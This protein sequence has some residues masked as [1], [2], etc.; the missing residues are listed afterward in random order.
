MNL[1]PERSAGRS[2]SDQ[3]PREFRGT[4]TTL[5]DHV[6]APNDDPARQIGGLMLG[7]VPSVDGNGERRPERPDIPTH[8]SRH[9]SLDRRDRTGRS[10]AESN[11]DSSAGGSPNPQEDTQ[12]RRLTQSRITEHFEA[13]GRVR[14]GLSR[15][16]QGRR[17]NVKYRTRAHIRV[18]SLNIRGGGSTATEEK[19]QQ[20]NRVM[21]EGKISVL[22]V[23]ETHLSEERT[24]ELNTQFAGR[25]KIY[26]SNED[27]VTNARGV[28]IVVDHNLTKG[29]PI[30]TRKIIPGRA[31]M[32]TIP[33]KNGREKLTFLAVYA[34]NERDQNALFWSRLSG[35]FDQE[36]EI[37][38]RPDFM[39]G[40]FNLTEDDID[41]LPPRPDN[42]DA[43]E[44]IQVLKQ[45]LEM[46][47]GWRME[48]PE[49]IMY[50]WARPTNQPQNE[51]EVSSKSRIDRIYI[52]RSRFPTSC[53]WKYSSH[54]IRSD[55]DIISAVYYDRESPYIGKGRWAIPE[56]LLKD[57]PFMTEVSQRGY[58]ALVKAQEATATA[59]TTDA[60]PQTV[61]KE[62]KEQIRS[63]AK[64]RS[65]REMP[66]TDARL[67]ELGKT[68]DEI[69][70]D[71]GIPDGE[72]LLRTTNI[73]AESKELEQ[74]RMHTNKAKSTTRFLLENETVGKYWIGL[75]KDKKPRDTIYGLY[76]PG[77]REGPMIH[78]SDQMAKMAKEYHEGL[79]KDGKCLEVGEDVRETAIQS[80]LDALTTRGKPSV[81][82]RQ[83]RRQA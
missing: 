15:V 8:G 70:N 42:E 47:D 12:R 63:L 25:M 55:H 19:W 34:P 67:A 53:D 45:K 60:N 51:N 59:R 30:T 37:A 73:D 48:N 38:P 68:K 9:T 62:Y 58:N 71:T 33:W 35:Y 5:A 82:H 43:M 2:P 54:P 20:I 46:V 17:K 3:N 29:G 76:S 31:I 50:S 21:K 23:Q 10:V 7:R 26:N 81:Q 75:N 28:A 69:L 27:D 57:D 72:K 74:K 24:K 1:P 6:E 64:D 4:G 79:Q 77:D 49:R 80:A 13:R 65:R 39:M 18:G 11:Q 22:A 40:D 66:K 78:R 44:A 61:W 16:D 41:R 52:L 36:E 56:F 14:V 32:T 83:G